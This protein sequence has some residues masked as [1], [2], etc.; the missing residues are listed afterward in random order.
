MEMTKE[1][2][3]VIFANAALTNPVQRRPA[4]KALAQPIRESEIVA[5]D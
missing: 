3:A 5:Q 2:N 1:A 4:A